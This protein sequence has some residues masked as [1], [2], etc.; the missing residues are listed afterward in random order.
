MRIARWIDE[1]R[2][3]K[4]RERK[5]LN[6]GKARVCIK[7]RRVIKTLEEPDSVK[8]GRKGRLIAQRV[9][10]EEHLLRVV[11]EEK[12]NEVVV[13]TFYPARRERYED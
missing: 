11:Y 9:L 6:S 8:I 10:D 3:H 12:D 13:I 2:I 5:I 7:R 1:N 4:P